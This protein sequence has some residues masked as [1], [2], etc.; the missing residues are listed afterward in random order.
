MTDVTESRVILQEEELKFNASVSEATMFRIGQTHNFIAKRQYDSHS[1]HFNGLVG[2]L[3][4]FNNQDGVM[5]VLFDMEIVSICLF[6]GTTGTSG[7]TELDVEWFDASSSNQG[8]IFTTK[9][10]ISAAASNSAYLFKR[11]TD[12]TLLSDPTGATQ[13]V[14]SKSEFDAGDIL[15]AKITDNASGAEDAHL[16]IQ[17]RPR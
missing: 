2:N 13:P 3:K 9:P 15:R 17:F 16:T 8:S 5:P 6:V 4:D 14:L 12:S 1:F 11:F 10:I 7:D